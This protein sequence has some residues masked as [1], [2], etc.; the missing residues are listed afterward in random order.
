MLQAAAVPL[1][2]PAMVASAT[3]LRRALPASRKYLRDLWGRRE[4]AWY[5]ANAN[6]K[7]RNASTSLGLLWWVINPLLLAGIYWLVFGVIFPGSRG[8]ADYLAYLISGIF[9]FYYTRAAM[10][11][12]V[13]SIL[14]NR[15]MLAN[16]NFPRLV[17]PATAILEG[18]VGFGASLAI[19]YPLL[20]PLGGVWPTAR[21]LW[22][23]PIF[24]IQTMFNFGLAAITARM[25]VPFRDI[26]NL[27]PYAL[28]LWLYLSPI[29][30]TVD[31]LEGTSADLIRLIELNPMFQI[32][33]VYRT[34]LLGD[35]LDAGDLWIALAWGFGMF[36]IGTF[37][38]VRYEGKMAR[39]L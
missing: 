15:R 16:L 25:A 26:N 11:G 14:G 18:A 12:G 39:Y 8:G 13:A 4:F 2:C 5:L 28:R 7:A 35:P 36:V 29:I 17:L 23:I 32:L 30:W 21:I 10:V 22:L 38:F 19:F 1:H 27:V 31:R 20:G 24:L 34:A 37:L 33:S 3:P 6:L 9:A